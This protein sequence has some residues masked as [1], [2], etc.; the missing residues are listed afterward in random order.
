MEN[1]KEGM[2]IL[3]VDDDP[4]CIFLTERI[5]TK[6]FC[7]RSV[8]SGHEALLLVEKEN[9]HLILMDI[10]LGDINMDGIRTMRKIRELNIGAP[11]IF[12]LTAFSYNKKWYIDQGFDDLYHKPLTH[13]I[14][15][16]INNLEFKKRRVA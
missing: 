4:L 2:R 16:V 1:I 6:N 14:I 9:F 15:P 7:I 13:E 3:I 12:A 11:Y 10:N 8:H 5:L